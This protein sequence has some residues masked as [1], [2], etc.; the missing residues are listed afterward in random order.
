MSDI[1]EELRAERIRQDDRW[2]G[3]HHDDSHAIEDWAFFIAIRCKAL[4]SDSAAYDP[5][6]RILVEIAALAIAAIESVDRIKKQ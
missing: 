2:G 3:P 5:A 4:K 1:Y 6:R